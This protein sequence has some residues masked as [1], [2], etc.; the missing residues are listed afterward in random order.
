VQGYAE[1]AREDL[2]DSLQKRDGTGTREVGRVAKP[3][4]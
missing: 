1:H 4:K 3:G 2:G